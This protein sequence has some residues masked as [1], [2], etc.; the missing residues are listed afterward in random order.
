MKDYY[1]LFVALALQ[2]CRKEDY[3]DKSKVKV[4]NAAMTKLR[5]LRSEIQRNGKEEVLSWRFGV[6]TEFENAD[7]FIANDGNANSAF[8]EYCKL[9]DYT[10]QALIDVIGEDVYV[11]AHAMSVTEGQWDER[12]FIEHCAKGT[13]YK[14]GET[15]T[16]I[17]YLSGSRFFMN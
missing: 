8:K 9:Y 15:G 5:K 1:N 16:K 3:A 13:N 17:C 11:G 2:Q 4:N 6:M 14:T 10:V 7:W 12:D